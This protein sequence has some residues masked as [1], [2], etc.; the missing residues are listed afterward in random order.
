MNGGEEMNLARLS[1]NGQITV[2]AEVRR[3][4]NVEAGDKIIFLRKSNGEIIVQNSIHLA[5]N[6]GKKAVAIASAKAQ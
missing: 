2:P 1:C 4:L 3:A 5:M 6:E